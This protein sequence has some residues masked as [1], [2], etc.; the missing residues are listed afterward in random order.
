[1]AKTSI[2]LASKSSARKQM[3]DQS[4]V[5]FSCMPADIDEDALKEEF[6]KTNSDVRKLALV[7]ASSKAYAI[8]ISQ[9]DQLVIGSDQ[10]LIC[11]GRFFS[12]VTTKAQALKQLADL[13]GKTHQLVSAVSCYKAGVEVFNAVESVEMTMHGLNDA[14]LDEYIQIAGEKILGS[15]GCYNI[16]TEGVRLFADIKGSYFAILGMPLLPLLNYLRSGKIT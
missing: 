9:P 15:V 4:G 16:E 7:L 6:L 14:E 8:S 10:L 5:I 3:L 1:M 13:Q 11:D 2:I 12:K